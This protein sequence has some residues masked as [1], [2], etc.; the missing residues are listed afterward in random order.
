MSRDGCTWSSDSDTK[1]TG[2][3]PVS[4]SHVNGSGRGSTTV[5]RKTA[6]PGGEGFAMKW[7]SCF[8]QSGRVI[9][10]QGRCSCQLWTVIARLRCPVPLRIHPRPDNQPAISDFTANI[11]AKKWNRM[12]PNSNKEISDFFTR[13]CWSSC[14][15]YVVSYIYL[16]I[17]VPQNKT[18][19][20]IV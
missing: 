6:G 14:F 17:S 13:Q 11:S 1:R 15:R 19:Q 18:I 10:V 12:K 16:K 5:T 4:R 8:L 3:E 20:K 2:P 9:S 7:H